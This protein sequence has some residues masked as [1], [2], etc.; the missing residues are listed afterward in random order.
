L[1]SGRPLLLSGMAD[2]AVL[3][4]VPPVGVMVTMFA[5]RR[6][7]FSGALEKSPTRA[8]GLVSMLEQMKRYALLQA[9]K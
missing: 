9:K 4:W 3:V 5:P 1:A 8:N 2:G 7:R 6:S